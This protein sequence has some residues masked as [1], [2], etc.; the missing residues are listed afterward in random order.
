MRKL[1][2]A[3]AAILTLS[4]AAFAQQGPFNGGGL[5]DAP[6]GTGSTGGVTTRTLPG[7]LGT[8]G[9]TFSSN[10][11]GTNVNGGIRSG[12]GSTVSATGS[13]SELGNMSDN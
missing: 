8:S 5:N 9:R 11:S 3:T 7:L 13:V 10:G 12:R 6:T 1:L 2:I 4:G